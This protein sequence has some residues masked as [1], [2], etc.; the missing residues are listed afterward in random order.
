LYKNSSSGL[1]NGGITHFVPRTV[2]GLPKG[3]DDSLHSTL[4]DF[5]LQNQFAPTKLRKCPEAGPPENYGI[6]GV[7]VESVLKV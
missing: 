3:F 7:F 2:L 1:Q 5:F 6:G 4:A